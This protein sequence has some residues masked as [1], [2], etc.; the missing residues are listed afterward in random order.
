MFIYIAFIVWLLK[1]LSLWKPDHIP[2]TVLWCICVAFVRLLDFQKANDR[3]FFKKSLKDNIKGLVFLEFFV[4]LYVF[5][6]WIEFLLVPIFTIIVGIQTIAERDK[7]YEIINKIIK[8]ILM[9]FGSFLIFY[10]AYKIITDFKN[11]ASL[12]NLESFYIPILL[13]MLFVP[14]VFFAALLAAYETFFVRLQFFVPEK[15]VL[16][17]AKLKSIF[18]IRFNLWKLNRW[19]DYI[20]RNW[21]FQSKQ[22]VRDA[23]A[24]FKQISA[25][26]NLNNE[27]MI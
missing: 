11:F 13:S 17:Y 3:N 21:R 9:V 26:S 18:S 19:S 15:S 16:R 25:I 4:N 23:V 1:S 2:L 27:E 22:E 6:F 8:F 10:V 7:E 12:Q 14:F 5:K 24:S 20:N